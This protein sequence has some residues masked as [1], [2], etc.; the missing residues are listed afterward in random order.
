MTGALGV[1]LSVNRFSNVNTEALPN[2]ELAEDNTL[3]VPFVEAYW[4]SSDNLLNP[5]RGHSSGSLEYSNTALVSDVNFQDTSGGAALPAAVVEDDLATRLEIGTIQPYGD[6][7][8]VPFNVRFFAGGPGS[9][10]GFAFNR[11]GPLDDEGDPIGG[12]SLIE[13]GVEVRFPLSVRSEGWCLLTLAMSF[14]M[15]LPIVWVISAMPQGRAAL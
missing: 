13:G 15:L 1:Q 5:T 3:L 14:R 10:R 7:E 12:K 9:V 6:T 4:N 8:E 11:L 2:E